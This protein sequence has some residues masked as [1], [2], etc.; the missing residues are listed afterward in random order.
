MQS[1]A[2][3]SITSR[4]VFFWKQHCLQATDY[5]SNLIH[6]SAVFSELWH[7]PARRLTA[8]CFSFLHVQAAASERCI[9][10][11]NKKEIRLCLHRASVYELP[12]NIFPPNLC[13]FSSSFLLW[14]RAWFSWVIVIFIGHS[15]DRSLLKVIFNKKRF[16]VNAALYKLLK[17]KYTLTCILPAH[18]CMCN[19][20]HCIHKWKGTFSLP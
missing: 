4:F 3:E 5:P 15:W 2:F 10:W 6:L 19:R 13:Q 17:T 9:S 14:R 18:S 12:I 8:I 1:A 7:S 20:N 16:N 11:C